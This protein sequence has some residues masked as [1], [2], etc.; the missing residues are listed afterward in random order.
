MLE[1]INRPT[2]RAR[3]RW[4]LALSLAWLGAPAAAQESA[5]D[6]ADFLVRSI[7]YEAF[8]YE[9]ARALDLEQVGYLASLLEEPARARDHANVILAL[10]IA[11]HPGSFEIVSAH[12]GAVAGEVSRTTWRLLRAR[13]TAM[14]HLARFDT[15]AEAWLVARARGEAP[16][17]EIS[18][19]AFRGDRMRRERQLQALRSL[20]L[21]ATDSA[22]DVLK[23]LAGDS[24]PSVAAAASEARG[25]IDQ[26]RAVG[27]DAYFR[28]LAR[29][30]GAG[31]AQP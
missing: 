3:W 6:A 4:L 28:E 27:A 29:D 16:E 1:R 2:R 7:Y 18:F 13:Y 8:P 31:E 22:R 9:E 5:L 11:G 26:I 12:P 20:P 24:D 23:E 30:S 17:S 15:R 14:G 19:R 21:A 10:G 25:R